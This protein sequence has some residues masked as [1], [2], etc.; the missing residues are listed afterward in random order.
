MEKKN[1][2]IEK[3]TNEATFVLDD[4]LLLLS[5]DEDKLVKFVEQLISI[6]KEVEVEVPNPPSRK[7]GDLR[8]LKNNVVKNPP[9]AKIKGD[10]K[11]ARRKN[12]REI[13]LQARAKT[14]K[15]C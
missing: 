3:L 8:N 10:V 5:K 15:K 6:K 13:A 14:K 2:T 1:E 9:G 4:C 7:T 11:G 12:G